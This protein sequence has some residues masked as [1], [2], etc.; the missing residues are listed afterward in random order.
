MAFVNSVGSSRRWVVVGA[1][2]SVFA[3]FVAFAVSATRWESAEAATNCS[4]GSGGLTS[5]ETQ[6][7]Q[8]INT[9]RAQNGVAPLLVSP[10]L[11]TAAAWKSEDMAGTGILD[12]TDSAGR[13]P[14]QRAVQCGYPGGAA[15]NAAMGYPTASAV[16][17]AWINSDGH[18][19]NLLGP[20]SVMG[21]GRSGNWWTLNL[22]FTVDQGSFP[23][24]SAPP[25]AGGGIATPTPRPT[26][27]PSSGGGA[28]PQPPPTDVVDEAPPSSAGNGIVPK[29]VLPAEHHPAWS[30]PANVPVKRAMMQMVASE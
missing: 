3:V 24:G 29:T 28:A 10:T 21:I 20:Y 4:T 12:H 18:R 15:E 13:S 16:V 8:L 25:P 2:L 23:V 17:Q 1:G 30:L 26:Q 6:A 11:N 14:Y 9:F 22:G 19:R 7:L 27:P 5:D